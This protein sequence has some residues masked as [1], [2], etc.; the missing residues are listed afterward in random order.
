MKQK[1]VFQVQLFCANCP[2]K[3]LMIIAGQKG[4]ESIAIEGVQRNE[5]VVIGEGIDAI[6]IARKLRGKVGCTDI[7]SFSE[8][9]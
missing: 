2:T 7:I 3:A 6:K 4:V 5:V 1:V 8:V 9:N